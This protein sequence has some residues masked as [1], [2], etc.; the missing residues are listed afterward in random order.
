MHVTK[1]CAVMKNVS[2][3]GKTL[4]NVIFSTLLL[5]FAVL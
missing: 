3:I 4:D 1:Y 5:Y 2:I